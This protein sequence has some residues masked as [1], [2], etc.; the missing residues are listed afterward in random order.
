MI[1]T[2]GFLVRSQEFLSAMIDAEDL[3]AVYGNT[4]ALLELGFSE[5]DAL[6]FEFQLREIGVLVYVTC[7]E[8]EGSASAL[9][10]LRRSGAREAA[11][12]HAFARKAS[13]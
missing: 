4:R 1:P 6:R 5:A 7:L 3:P 2:V 11:P 9:Q 10:A 8:G 13:A 12:I